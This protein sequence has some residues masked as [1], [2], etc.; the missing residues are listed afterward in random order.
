MSIGD[1]LV[2]KDLVDVLFASEKRKNVLL[3]LKDGP[4][5][6]D[7]ILANLKTIRQALLPQ[8]KILKEHDLLYQTDDTYR[9]TSTGQLIVDEM[10]PFLDTIEIIDK[11]G[12]Y[13]T[14]HNVDLLP[15]GLKKRLHE[16]KNITLIEPDHVNSA[17]LN[18]DYLLECLESRSIQFVYTFMHVGAMS[19][20]DKLIAKGMDISII[21]TKELFQKLIDDMY[22][23]FKFAL[24]LEN[25]KVYVYEQPITITSLTLIDTGFLLRLLSSNNEF[26]NK[27]II[28]HGTEGCNWGQDLYDHYLK[29]SKLITEI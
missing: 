4:Q 9:L 21:F 2:K 5:E 12:H 8:M 26:S 19:V 1:S 29:D 13:F 27:Q 28:C 14:T 11:Y 25:V 24:S 17:E 3:L 22:D 18:S 20:L 23:E 16:I 10:K 15:S 6:M 7:T